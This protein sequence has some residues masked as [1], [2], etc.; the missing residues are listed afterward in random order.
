MKNSHPANA[1]KEQVAAFHPSN[2]LDRPVSLSLAAGVEIGI[3]TFQPY[4]R[5]LH[6]AGQDELR[7]LKMLE[8]G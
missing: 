4:H 3:A 1:S 7:G 2:D 8:K 5:S 6:L